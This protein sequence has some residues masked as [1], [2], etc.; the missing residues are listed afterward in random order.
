MLQRVQSIFLGLVFIS[1]ILS[2]L[3]GH[4]QKFD[5]NS[6]QSAH[7]SAIKL[8]HYND[9]NQ[10]DVNSESWTFYIAIV[11]LLAAGVAV[12]STFAYKK[13]LTQIKLGALNSLLMGGAL[14]LSVYFSLQGQELFDP[15]IKGAYGV[16][17]YSIFAAL[18][19]NLLA[20]R[21]IRRDEQLVRSVDRI[22]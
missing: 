11:S 8:V 12:Y 19:F 9:I 21:F 17:F 4:W 15:N 3:S 16:G 6:D 13:R 22:R 2:V 5:D 10:N 1:M 14:G 20:N 18:I 7:L